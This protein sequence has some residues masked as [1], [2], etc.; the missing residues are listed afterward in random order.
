MNKNIITIELFFDYCVHLKKEKL[1]NSGLAVNGLTVSLLHD[2][3]DIFE[4]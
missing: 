2:S 4:D 1:I 3:N